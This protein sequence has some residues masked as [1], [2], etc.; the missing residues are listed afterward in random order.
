MVGIGYATHNLSTNH[1]TLV[2]HVF[3]FFA[4][5]LVS[6]HF[7]RLRYLQP[8]LIL[9]KVRTSVEKQAL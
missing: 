4:I 9:N 2:F 3:Y 1:V 7:K 5:G 8:T 6:G